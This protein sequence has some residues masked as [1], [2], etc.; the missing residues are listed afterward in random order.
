MADDSYCGYRQGRLSVVRRVG[1]EPGG[2]Y[3]I[4]RLRWGEPFVLQL[5]DEFAMGEARHVEVVLCNLAAC[6]FQSTVM[7]STAYA[8][9]GNSPEAL[10][11]RLPNELR[12]LDAWYYDDGGVPAGLQD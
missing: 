12:S 3:S 4:F 11:D 6:T 5:C 1:L 8:R 2:G 7:W 9:R 10:A